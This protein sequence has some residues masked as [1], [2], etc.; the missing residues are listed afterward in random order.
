[1]DISVG[2]PTGAREFKELTK[3]V[4]EL[5][6]YPEISEEEFNQMLKKASVGYGKDLPHR[7]K[8]LCPETRKV[9]DAVVWEKNGKVW[10]TKRCPEGLIT[11]LYYEDVNTYQR[12]KKWL[13][14]KKVLK[15]YHID[16][17]GSNCPFECGLCR[18]HY[19][20]TCLLNIVLTNRCDLSCWYCLP[21]NERVLFKI[22]D[23]IK[24]LEIGKVSKGLK[25]DRK[26]RIDGFEGEY[27]T[28]DN[29]MVLTFENGKAKWTRVTKFL[30]RFYKG[31][32]LKIRTRGG[33]EVRLT[34]EHRV[35]VYEGGSVTKKMARDLKIGD[36]VICLLECEITSPSLNTFNTVCLCNQ[37]LEQAIHYGRCSYGVCYL[38]AAQG[39]Y[40]NSWNSSFSPIELED[41]DNE[42][43]TDFHIIQD[44]Y[45]DD[46]CEIECYEYSGFVYDLEVESETH[47]FVAADGILVSNCFFYAKEG[48][49]IYEPTLEQIRMMLKKAKEEFPACNAVQLSLDYDEKILIKDEMGYIRPV[50]IGEFVDGLIKNSRKFSHPIPHERK[51]IESFYALSIDDGLNPSFCK[52][53]E[54]IRHRNYDD[55]LEIEVDYGWKVRVSRSHSVFKFDGDLKVVRADELR[56]GD[57]LIGTLRIPNGKELKYIDILEIISDNRQIAD[58][59]ESSENHLKAYVNCSHMSSK[60][61]EMEDVISGNSNKLIP[62]NIK[63]SKDL[64]RL[65][66]Y[67]VSR[68]VCNGDSIKFRFDLE[69]R[70]LVDDCIRCIKN[71]FGIDPYTEKNY[72]LISVV[73]RDRILRTILSTMFGEKPKER[74]LSWV[75]FN[76]NDE[77]KLEFLRTYLRCNGELRVGGYRYE[78]IHNVFCDELARDLVLLHL[79]LGI[80]PKIRE[81]KGSGKLKKIFDEYDVNY[82]VIVDG[83][84]NIRKASMYAEH[85]AI[86]KFLDTGRRRGVRSVE[87]LPLKLLNINY[88]H[89]SISKMKLREIVD[90]MIADSV[91][92]AEIL[93]HISHSSVGFFRVK[94]IRRVKPKSCYLYDISIPDSQAFFAGFGLLLVHNTGGEP[95]LREDLIEIIRIAKEEGYDHV[96]LNTDGIRLA[97][98][99][100]LVRKIKEAGVNTIYL[101]Y[102][103]MTPLTNW[104]NHWEIPLI[105][106]N[107]RRAGG[108]GVVLVPTVIRN[109][110]DHELGAIINFG[111]NHIDIVRGVNFQ[112][113]SMVGRVPKEERRMFRIT[114]PKALKEIEEQTNGAISVEDWY[115]VPIAGHIARFFDVLLDKRYYMTSH[116]ACG[117]ATYV[118]LDG[119]RVIPITRFIDVEGFVEFLLEKV[120]EFE[121]LDKTKKIERLEFLIKKIEEF[122]RKIKLGKDMIFKFRKFYDESR[123]PKSLKILNIIKNVLLHGTYATLGEFHRK[124]LFLGMMH[125]QDEYN[126]DVERTERCVIHYGMPDGRIVPFCAFNVIPEVYRDQIQ[127]KYSYSREQYK[128]LHPDWSYKKDKYFRTKEFIEKMMSSEVYR[129]TYNV[130][131]YFE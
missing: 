11:E 12:F 2:V 84:E 101:S 126:Y 54:V 117:C 49:P 9:V 25:F 59:S 73:I 85:D 40:D 98:N 61:L 21:G 32:I 33:K 131:N 66:G 65:F 77:F 43:G 109:I 110:N 17:S 93:N 107:V 20:H 16:S 38:A 123:A 56:E 121:K 75:M 3:E 81:V 24:F 115:P 48:Q 112:P 5:I 26:V 104:K 35:F 79:Q 74:R 28:P 60:Q 31:K 50:K 55:I 108:P 116:F 53:E 68:A 69:E 97:F 39:S 13:F 103:G 58:V 34:P 78:I 83:L 52:I 129:K 6:E 120:E 57:I 42:I 23:D 15:T 27:S 45:L 30:R 14:S 82:K 62:A 44:F 76:I 47:S 91:K 70:E 114:I 92:F 99:P 111:L 10:I 128:K 63:I 90:H 80:I 105:F 67:Y 88:K 8:S 102:D 118:F 122:E 119:D 51:R 125:F 41:S 130:K 127:E 87:R 29:L 1:M 94:R 19:S 106:E 95:T 37:S 64:M 113:I 7:T 89:K 124:A 100:E 22:G 86:A 71:L 4:K 46:V 18:R 96:Q 36:K 72:D